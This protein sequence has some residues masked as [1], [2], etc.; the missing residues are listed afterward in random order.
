MF[1]FECNCSAAAAAASEPPAQE[2]KKGQNHALDR[3]GALLSCTT[4]ERGPAWR[5]LFFMCHDLS[6][7]GYAAS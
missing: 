7:G 4:P 3:G 1:K 2:V 6:N 5:L